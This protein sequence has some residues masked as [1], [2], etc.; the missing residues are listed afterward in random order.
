M[1]CVWSEGLSASRVTSHLDA[2]SSRLHLTTS[3]PNQQVF[4]RLF[5][6]RVSRWTRPRLRAMRI[7]PFKYNPA[8]R[9]ELA[10]MSMRGNITGRNAKEQGKWLAQSSFIDLITTKQ[11]G[12]PSISRSRIP[13]ESEA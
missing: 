3:R 11:S 12:R 9:P 10:W 4:L 8:H 5:S 2:P 1:F 7:L 6:R 13:K